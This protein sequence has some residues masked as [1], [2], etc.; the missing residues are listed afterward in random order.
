MVDKQAR[1]MVKIEMSLRL[2]GLNTWSLASGIVW[3]VCG[4]FGRWCLIAKDVTL[5]EGRS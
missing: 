5:M 4:T 2:Q 3:E 1:I